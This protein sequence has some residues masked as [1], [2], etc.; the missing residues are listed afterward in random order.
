MQEKGRSNLVFVIQA[1]LGSTFREKQEVGD[2]GSTGPD[3]TGSEPDDAKA[4]LST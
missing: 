3:T 4:Q 2:Y 1:G